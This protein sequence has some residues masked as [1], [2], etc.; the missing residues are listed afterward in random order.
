MAQRLRL[1]FVAP[2]S[3]TDPSPTSLGGG[4]DYEDIYT[5]VQRPDP[6]ST[7]R[8]QDPKQH[9]S[10]GER[11]E[12]RPLPACSQNSK[13]STS[14]RISLQPSRCHGSSQPAASLTGARTR[15]ARG[16]RRAGG[17]PPGLLPDDVAFGRA[18]GSD[19]GACSSAGS[20]YGSC[21]STPSDGSSCTSGI[22][23]DSSGGSSCP[24]S[25]GEGWAPPDTA[26][27]ASGRSGLSGSRTAWGGPSS[28]KSLGPEEPERPAKPREGLRE[29]RVPLRRC[30]SLVVFPRSPS[31]TPPRSPTSPLP[32]GRPSWVSLVPNKDGAGAQGSLSTTL[33]GLQLSHGVAPPGEARDVRPL[34][35]NCPLW[36]RPSSTQEGAPMGSSCISFHV[37]CGR[38]AAAEEAGPAVGKDPPAGL[39]PWL[40]AA[41]GGAGMSSGGRS[42]APPGLHRSLSVGSPLAH[43][44]SCSE[45]RASPHWHIQLASSEREEGAPRGETFGRES[46]RRQ[47]P[48]EVSVS[49]PKPNFWQGLLSV[50]RRKGLSGA[51]L[52]CGVLG[53]RS[54]PP[55]SLSCSQGCSAE[56]P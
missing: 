22:A 33:C 8:R 28:R 56:P 46:W 6:G 5:Q 15:G 31:G 14:L 1:R 48:P 17:S 53:R 18:Q 10:G 49:L 25:A 21:T 45:A 51:S 32:S 2:R 13:K 12:V 47:Q 16:S 50:C 42:R 3:R 37:A 27:G 34:C 38:P 23:S 35:G 19:A 29:S 52:S 30:S 39:S 11:Q 36:E 44:R 24:W 20:D 43:L 7:Q 54:A 41:E 9:L 26:A 55:C 4:L 40:S